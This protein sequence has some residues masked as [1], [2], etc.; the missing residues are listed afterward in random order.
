[1][2][3]IHPTTGEV[4]TLWGR[5]GDKRGLSSALKVADKLNGEGF[6]L[7]SAPCLRKEKKGNADSAAWVPVLWIDIDSTDPRDL[8]KLKALNPTPSFIIASGSGWHAYWLLEQPFTLET[9][10]DKQK[11][12]AIL[13]GLFSALD[14][15]SG[16]VKSVT[17]VMRL[18]NSANTKP[19]RGGVAV[20]IVESDPERRYALSDFA[21]LESDAREERIGNMRVVTL[22][23]N[24]H[25]PLEWA[26]E[27]KRLKAVCGD[28]FRVEDLNSMYKQARRTLERGQ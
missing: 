25:H 16:Y 26:E 15:D 9:D 11:V 3:C 14:G 2:R 24:G 8:E 6:G 7:Y 28:T 1:L 21:W 23:A 12:A 27:R 19:E 5:M 20:E 4:Q 10:A 22:N 18:P 13:R 17:S